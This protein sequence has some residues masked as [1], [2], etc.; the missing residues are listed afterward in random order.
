MT[1]ADHEDLPRPLPGPFRRGADATTTGES[2][3]QP[4]R[5]C[6]AQA[7]NHDPYPAWEIIHGGPLWSAQHCTR[8]KETER[9]EA[10]HELVED[11][12]FGWVLGNK[13]KKWRTVA[14]NIEYA[15]C[16]CGRYTLA[17][18]GLMVASGQPKHGHTTHDHQISHA[19]STD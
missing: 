10:V 2:E 16:G 15:E 8:V 4:P 11:L 14:V 1:R 5:P 7:C 12:F 9:N 13:V 6:G 3:A 18:V 19:N 17:E